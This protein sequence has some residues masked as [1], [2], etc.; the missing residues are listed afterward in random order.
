M[1][2]DKLPYNY[3]S[4]PL[5]SV[6]GSATFVGKPTEKQIEAVNKMAKLAFKQ[7]KKKTTITMPLPQNTTSRI[8]EEAK[9]EP[10]QFIISIK[11]WRNTDKYDCPKCGNKIGNDTKYL[12]APCNIKIK[13]VINF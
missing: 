12:C 9:A 6:K 4:V 8:E 2:K 5:K 1:S 7:L 11:S 13:P 10:M 3:K